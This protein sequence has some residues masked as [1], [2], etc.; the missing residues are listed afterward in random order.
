MTSGFVCDPPNL[1]ESE[2]NNGM[3]WRSSNNINVNTAYWT[4]LK[5]NYWWYTLA[6]CLWVVSLCPVLVILP[7]GVPLV[8][9]ALVRREY[10]LI[11]TIS[12]FINYI[13]QVGW[14][15][16]EMWLQGMNFAFRNFAGIGWQVGRVSR[17]IFYLK[18]CVGTCG[19]YCQ[20]LL[21]DSFIFD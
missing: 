9:V 6:F 11:Q 3:I 8:L 10:F 2:I 4:R 18:V 1:R 15:K 21:S 20:S 5:Y 14:Q 13:V 16:F 12:T 17:E 7:V 19:Y